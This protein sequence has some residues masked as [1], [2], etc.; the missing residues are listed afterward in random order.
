MKTNLVKGQSIIELLVT[1]ALMAILIPA[2][3][4]VF[5][6]SREGN[7]QEGYI[8]KVQEEFAKTKEAILIIRDRGFE[9]ISTNGVFYIKESNNSFYLHQNTPDSSEKP[10]LSVHISSVYRNSDQTIVSNG[11]NIDP[12]T[13]KITLKI[14]K[15]QLFQMDS[16]SSF[17][18]TRHAPNFSLIQTTKADFEKGFTQETSITNTGEIIL[19]KATTEG[20]YESEIFDLGYSSA[21]NTISPKIL[22]PLKTKVLYQISLVDAQNENCNDTTNNFVGPDGMQDTFYTG[23]QMVRF[24]DDGQGFE[25]PGRCFAYKVYLFTEDPNESPVFEEFQLNFSQ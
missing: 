7:A 24:E 9:N 3:V 20:Y 23:T 1:M 5:I 25:N 16:E 18:L 13:K 17:Y 21:I 6:Q 8:K 19:Q 12:L 15:N 22:T 11:G 14:L 4:G 10:V 2:I